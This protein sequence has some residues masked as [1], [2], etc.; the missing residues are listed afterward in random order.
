MKKGKAFRFG[1]KKDKVHIYK[2]Q[3]CL[4]I[5]LL[6]VIDGLTGFTL[7]LW[8]SKM[9]CHGDRIDRI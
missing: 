8:R 2:L 7:S 4:T 3:K 1:P 6:I 5:R 9:H